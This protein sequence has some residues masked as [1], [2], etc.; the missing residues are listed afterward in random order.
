MFKFFGVS[1]AVCV[2][3]SLCSAT[4]SRRRKH[5]GKHGRDDQQ[6]RV[7]SIQETTEE[8]KTHRIMENVKRTVERD[9]LLIFTAQEIEGPTAF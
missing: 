1:R 4:D 3:G 7:V 5:A 6:H 8:S 9:H 2:S